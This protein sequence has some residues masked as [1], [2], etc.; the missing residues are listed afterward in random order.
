M[1][2]LNKIFTIALSSF[3]VFS[4]MWNN[5]KYRCRFVDLTLAVLVY[6]YS[7]IFYGW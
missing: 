2:I 1:D 7:C 3:T 6:L 4:F 5:Y